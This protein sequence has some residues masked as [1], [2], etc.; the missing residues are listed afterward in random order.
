MFMEDVNRYNLDND[1]S[2]VVDVCTI[3]FDVD[4]AYNRNGLFLLQ[5]LNV[6]LTCFSNDYRRGKRNRWA[7]FKSSD[8]AVCVSLMPF[9]KAWIHFF[10]V[11]SINK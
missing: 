11:Q 8:Q 2:S 1:I 3:V 9:E 5:E 4:L 6:L 7:W 10:S